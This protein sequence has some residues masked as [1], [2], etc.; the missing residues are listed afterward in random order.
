MKRQPRKTTPYSFE[1]DG[2]QLPIHI[3]RH[4]T[5][6]RIIIRYR[7]VEHS[8]ALTLPNY[9]S[10]RQGLSFI[11][12]RRNWIISR[13]NE[14]SGRVAFAD[15]SVLPVAGV[16]HRI[17]HVGG[18]GLV[19]AA[20]GD[21]L[22]PSTKARGILYVPGEAEFVARRVREWLRQRAMEEIRAAVE[23]KTPQLEKKPRKITLRDTSSRW[24]SCSTRGDL[25][26]SWRL[27]LAPPAVLDYL[28]CHELAHL[29]YM[30]HSKQFWAQVAAL[31]PDYEAHE[32]W[33]NAH[34][35]TLYAYG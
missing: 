12:E 30:N 24:G 9:V 27:V 11:E 28:V 22:A 10:H 4:K 20:S 5:S 16:E 2:N 6:R 14:M 35:Q 25:S 17:S 31:C 33:L 34:G 18:R 13:I 3:R 7:P 23:R 8:I 32:R 1:Y 15:G 21:P 29:K 26:F 19:R